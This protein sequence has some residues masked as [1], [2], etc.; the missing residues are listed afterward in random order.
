M[1]IG[2]E[3]VVDFIIGQDK[4]T[5]GNLP[6]RLLYDYLEHRHFPENRIHITD[7][8]IKFRRNIKHSP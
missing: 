2:R 3:G 6:L 7:I 8:T 5:Q 4:Q 1:K